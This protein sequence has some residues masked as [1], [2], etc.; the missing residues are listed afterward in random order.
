M[1][2]ASDEEILRFSLQQ[3]A[4]AI[5]LDVDFHAIL[6][7]SGAGGLSVIRVRRQGL[8]AAEI[9]ELIEKALA[10]LR[11]RPDGRMLNQS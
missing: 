5:T 3:N 8:D 4:L 7:V 2:K 11:C 9:V 6:A 1:S 10:E